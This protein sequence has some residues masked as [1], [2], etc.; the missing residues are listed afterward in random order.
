LPGRKHDGVWYVEADS[1]PVL[2]SSTASGRLDQGVQPA[3]QH[4]EDGRTAHEANE[5]AAVDLSPLVALVDRLHVENRQ[6]TEAATA[7]QIRAMQAEERL[8]ALEA[9]TADAA[10]NAPVAANEGRSEAMPAAMTTDVA[11]P[12]A[13]FWDRFWRMVTGRA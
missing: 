13:S 9:G 1:L 11:R 6:L 2:A 5:P 4:G 3:G 12:N 10:T 7:W 8:K